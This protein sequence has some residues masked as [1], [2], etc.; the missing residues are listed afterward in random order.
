[1]KKIA[2]MMLF[3]ALCAAAA[4]AGYWY[5]RHQEHA[6]PR[7]S[8][9]APPAPQ[10]DGGRK[11]L[12][13]YDP[14]FPQQRFEKPGKSPFMDMQLVPKY[15]D[16]APVEGG[17]SIDPRVAQNLGV[18]TDVV[19]PG[20]LAGTFSAVGTVAYNERSIVL[21]QSRVNGYVEKLHVRAPLDAVR[22]G[23]P[24]VEMLFPEWAA[25]QEEFLL[26]RR[27]ATPDAETLR[28]AARQRLILLGMSED[29]I[30]AVEREAT[31][32]TRVT[33]RSPIAGV[34]AELGAR[35]GMTAMAGTTLFRIAG[36]G[37]VWVVAEV[38]EAQ[39]AMVV[40]GA[41]VAVQVPA[42]PG[43]KFAGG[44]GAI[45]PE[46]NTATRTVR[47]RIEVANTA[48]KLKPGMF[49]N[50]EFAVPGREALLVP[51]E[52]VIHTGERSVVI[53]AEDA[54]RFRAVDVETGMETRGSTEIRKGLRAGDR[55]V[56]SGQFLI[57]SEA[58]L[59]STLGRLGSRS[60]PSATQPA[61][62]ITPSPTA[63]HSGGGQSE[64]ARGNRP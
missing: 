10:A 48:G 18:R 61:P 27:L 28:A 29:Q 13:W 49:A 2:A 19:R 4:A 38:P 56:I 55:V 30:V 22:A 8:P 17:V 42:Y 45:L 16:E 36:L 7:A 54:G 32:Q 60:E 59:R 1:M 33:L 58:S 5:A 15:A 51:S 50:L 62:S 26:L 24:L 6:V 41:K 43:E 39:A 64:G 14:M 23:A 47:A 57:D 53:I 25:A 20:S 40:P 12:Y 46:I 34:I 31:V 11:V 21:V 63:P 3:A 9:T 44:V 35:E 52:A 37:T